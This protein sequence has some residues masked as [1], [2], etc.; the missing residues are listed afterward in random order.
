ME[1]GG[2]HARRTRLGMLHRTL[3]DG[4]GQRR[5]FY[6]RVRYDAIGG[7]VKFRRTS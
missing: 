4:D 3:T 2:L 1:R 5:N 7:D 6:A